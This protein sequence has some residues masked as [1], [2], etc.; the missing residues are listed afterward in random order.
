MENLFWS[1]LFFFT[2]VSIYQCHQPKDELLESHLGNAENHKLQW[3][4]EQQSTRR[5]HREQALH[6]SISNCLRRRIC[7]FCLHYVSG[8]RNI[9]FDS[10]PI[11]TS[12][13]ACSSQLTLSSTALMRRPHLSHWSPRASGYLQWGQMPS[14]KRSARK[15]WQFSQRSCSTVSSMRKPRLWSRQKMSWAI[16]KERRNGCER[17]KG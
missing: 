6:K 3:L 11:A 2:F 17:L 9:L 14:T 8:R 15:R 7:L 4:Q 16:L 13:S 1:Y 10:P 5:V 12:S